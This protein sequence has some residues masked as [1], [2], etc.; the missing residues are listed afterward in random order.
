[1]VHPK[2][3]NLLIPK[4]TVYKNCFCEYNRSQLGPKHRM[5]RIWFLINII[6]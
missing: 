4:V 3:D 1:M 6:Y 2:K 5:D